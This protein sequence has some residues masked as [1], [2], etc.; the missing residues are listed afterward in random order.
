[1]ADHAVSEVCD[2]VLAPAFKEIG[3]RWECGQAEV[4]QERRGCGVA[5]RVIHEMHRLLP[6]PQ[7]EAPKAV[8]G[9]AAGDPYNLATTMVE[10][11]LREA[12]WNAVSL[13]DNL[14]FP[15]LAASLRETQPRLFWLSCS[16]IPDE[17]EFLSRYAELFEQF[18]AQVA[19]VVGGRALHV[20]LRRKMRYAAY[21]DNMRHLEAFAQT[22]I[23]SPDQEE[24]PT[25]EKDGST[26]DDGTAG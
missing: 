24:S 6:P 12:G 26:D 13:G 25:D 16:H 17:A 1:M 8:G 4:Y 11:V 19:F 15:T 14:P 9:A 10:V 21:C 2:L 18:G 23:N 7:P 5:Q 22:L 20:E 3:D